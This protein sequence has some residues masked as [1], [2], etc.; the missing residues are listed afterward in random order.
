MMVAMHSLKPRST[1]ME[2]F[3]DLLKYLTLPANVN[4][5]SLDIIMDMNIP[6]SVKEGTRKQR[7]TNP[8]P[9]DDGWKRFLG[10]GDNKNNLIALFVKFLKSTESE[11]Y[12]KYIV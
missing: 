12:R 7:S 4:A 6:R 3:I 11:E 5:H 9:N 10:N 1:Y 8:G 2:C